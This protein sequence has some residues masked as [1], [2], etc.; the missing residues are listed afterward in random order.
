[1]FSKVS[2]NK[3]ATSFVALLVFAF[4]PLILVP[5]YARVAG[6]AL[7]GTAR[8]ESGTVIPQA[9]IST[10]NIATGFTRSL[11]TD[12]AR[13]YAAPCWLSGASDVTV[14]ASRFTSEA[15]TGIALTVKRLKL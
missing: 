12:A 3:T 7:S 15:E 8:D 5:V 6:A 2:A 1:M 11:T 14:T 13:F 4:S 10:R 9:Q